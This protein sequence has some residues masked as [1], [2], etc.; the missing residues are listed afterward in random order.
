M[1]SFKRI[2]LGA[3]ILITALLTVI[4]PMADNVVEGTTNANVVIGLGSI[5]STEGKI[6]IDDPQGILTS[7]NYEAYLGS[8]LQTA[9]A[10]RIYMF[11]GGNAENAQINLSVTLRSDAPVGACATFNYAGGY[12]NA[13]DE[14]SASGLTGSASV[15]IVAPSTPPT[16]TPTPTPSTPSKPGTGVK[17]NYSGLFNQ[18]SFAER[19]NAVESA[20]LSVALNSA[21]NLMAEQDQTII[22]LVAAMLEVIIAGVN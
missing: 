12:T 5:K 15:C 18:I 7:V 9:N 21:K 11:T 6:S 19:L 13:N 8:A 20:P 17:V 2:M 3:V 16:P 10:D 1:K 4:V 22:D 14:Y